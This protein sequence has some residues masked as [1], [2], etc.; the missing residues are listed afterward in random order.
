[1]IREVTDI[2]NILNEVSSNLQSGGAFFVSLSPKIFSFSLAKGGTIWRIS[3]GPGTCLQVKCRPRTQVYV[4]GS[5]DCNEEE[6]KI[7][8]FEN[9]S[10]TFGKKARPSVCKYECQGC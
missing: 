3:V 7:F 4:I 2:G 9:F 10:S 1:M 8:L 5:V 6:R